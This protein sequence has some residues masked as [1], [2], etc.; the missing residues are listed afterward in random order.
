MVSAAF[1][2]DQEIFRCWFPGL[3]TRPCGGTG[4]ARAYFTLTAALVMGPPVLYCR[5][6]TFVIGFAELRLAVS[7]LSQPGEPASV[8]PGASA[9]SLAETLC[10]PVRA[11]GA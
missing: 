11:L 2:L 8:P 9:I 3:I 1:P 7:G 5:Q 4:C 6:R 10:C